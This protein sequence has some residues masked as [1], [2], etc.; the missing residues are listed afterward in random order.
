MHPNLVGATGP[1]ARLQQ[2]GAISITLHNSELG[3]CFKPFLI[4]NIT[5]PGLSGMIGY[6][7]ITH[8]L[9]VFWMTLYPDLIDF[10]DPAL[11]EFAL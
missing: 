1:R 11:D 6:R 3:K 2:C 8:K 7:S 4:I 9:V 5:A 10:F